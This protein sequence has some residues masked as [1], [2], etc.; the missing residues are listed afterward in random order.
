MKSK[1][2]IVERIKLGVVRDELKSEWDR[3]FKA[4]QKLL[5]E[6]EQFQE[7]LESFREELSGKFG[8]LFTPH[9]NSPMYRIDPDGSVYLEYCECPGCQAE[10][11]NMSVSDTVEE[12]YQLQR[13][14]EEDIEVAR[15]AAK[16]ADIQTRAARQL[17]N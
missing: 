14:P 1:F 15:E 5:R 6:Q 2:E 9:G 3:L 11:H 16:A 7:D 17:P 4:Q 10:V 12:L 13:I 8:P